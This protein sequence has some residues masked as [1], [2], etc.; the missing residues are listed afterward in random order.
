MLAAAV[1]GSGIYGVNANAG[2]VSLKVLDTDGLG[3][4]YDVIRAIDSAVEN[5]IK[6]LNLSF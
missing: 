6:V 4:S 1:N 5:G 2:F 3:T